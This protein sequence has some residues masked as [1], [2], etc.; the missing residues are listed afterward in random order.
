M[1]D[2]LIKN[3]KAPSYATQENSKASR[4][5]PNKACDVATC[6]VTTMIESLKTLRHP[7]ATKISC[8][9]TVL[10]KEGFEAISMI[11]HKNTNIGK[12]NISCHMNDGFSDLIIPVLNVASLI[13]LNISFCG[14]ISPNESYA[15]MRLM[16]GKN[17]TT[18]KT[19]GTEIP[20]FEYF[21]AALALS[22]VICLTYSLPKDC[23]ITASYICHI[24][25]FGGASVP[26]ARDGAHARRAA[27]VTQRA[28][29]RRAPACAGAM[30]WRSSRAR[31][32]H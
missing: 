18:L 11:L 20:W 17:L 29:R 13:H 32:M 31:S 1:P 15:L 28:R 14:C 23:C 22:S 25:D 26:L 21:V 5:N 10:T 24:H 2:L 4:S 9:E 30:R 27:E 6:A 7:S 3:V 19:I 8:K 16:M 12:L